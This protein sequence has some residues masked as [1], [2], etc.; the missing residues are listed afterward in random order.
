MRP[1][2]I[3]LLRLL[4]FLMVALVATD[5][6]TTIIDHKGPWDHTKAAAW[7]VWATYPALAVFG[8]IRPLRWLPLVIFT[9]IYKMIWLVIVAYPLWKTD[10]LAGNPAEEMASAFIIAP[11]LVLIIPW[12]Y[13]FRNFV[14]WQ[15]AAA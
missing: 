12:G 11:F 4:Y 14:L 5:A 1:V 6:W 9:M 13:V 2:N 3:Y 15:K 7:C 10:T 8:L